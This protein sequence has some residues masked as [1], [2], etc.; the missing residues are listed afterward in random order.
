[1]DNDTN[2]IPILKIDEKDFELEV[3][4]AKL[5]VMVAFEAPW[6]R[7]CNVLLTVLRE[8]TNACSGR[9]KVISIDVDGNPDL[10]LWYGIRSIPTL[11]FFQNGKVRG[12]IVGTTTKEVILSKLHSVFLGDDS[13]SVDSDAKKDDEYII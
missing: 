7:P 8:V 1:M 6:S 2:E 11:V 12:K 4:R 3:L 10:G 13:S 5:P 9:V